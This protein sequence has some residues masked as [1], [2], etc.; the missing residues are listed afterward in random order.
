MGRFDS[1]GDVDV[2]LTAMIG[3]L[4]AFDELARRYRPAVTS[5]ARAITRDGELV[6][7]VVQDVLI[8]AYTKLHTLRDPGAFGAWLRVLT[9]RQARRA[10]EGERR[11][12]GP[13]EPLHVAVYLACPNVRPDAEVTR[14]E[15]QALV[16]RAIAALSPEDVE[17]VEL[18][19][20]DGVPL[21]RIADYL[22]IT[23]DGAKWRL[24]RA[25]SQL[26]KSLRHLLEDEE[27]VNDGY[28][29]ARAVH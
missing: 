13:I 11:Q 26:R 3:D 18:R 28:R 20:I 23:R 25:N 5:T 15:Q 21:G 24:K 19:Y 14:R 2:T 12:P 17:L 16:R 6:R 1:L 10:L 9:E 7:D 27:V 22:G 4:E 29:A 8:T